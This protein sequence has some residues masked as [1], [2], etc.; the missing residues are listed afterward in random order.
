MGSRIL[1]SAIAA[2]VFATAGTVS[3][4]EPVGSLARIS[5]TVLVNQGE[6]YRTGI[7]GMALRPGD[8]IM[9]MSAGSAVIQFSDGCAYDLDDNEV[10]TIGQTSTCSADT[11]AKTE[12]G[13]YY[14]QP[15]APVLGA[16]AYYGW[17]YGAFF[18]ATAG[19]AASTGGAP[20]G[21]RGPISPP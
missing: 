17:Q 4:A 6:Q 2:V 19:V 16:P 18:G 10:L 8:R 20:V 21:P 15:G 5:G 7:E 13:K 1:E 3:A 12:I 14:A 9:A 11:I